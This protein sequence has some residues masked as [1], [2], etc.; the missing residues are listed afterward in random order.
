MLLKLFPVLVFSHNNLLFFIS[1]RTSLIV[2]AY[3][4]QVA[5]SKIFGA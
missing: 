1:S 3:R 2:E 5:L 4:L